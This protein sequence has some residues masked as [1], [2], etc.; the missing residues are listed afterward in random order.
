M[1]KSSLY[2]IGHGHKAIEEFIAELLAYD[3][4]FLIDVRSVPFSKW[5]PQFNQGN[6]ENYLKKYSIRYAYMGDSIGGRPLNDSC[7]DEDGYL[8]YERMAAFPQFKD[9][10]QRLINA[11]TLGYK[12]A[13]MCSETDPSQCHRSKLIGRELYF[14]HNVDMQHIV[15]KTRII[16]EPEII[17]MLTKGRWSPEPSLF[18]M[19]EEFQ[20]RPYFR[21][22]NS[23]KNGLEQE[24]YYD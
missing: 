17:A 23:Y 12:V 22:R 2:S 21:S 16:S 5:A 6:I 8:L 9:G 13:V 15:S 4:R 10:L 7:Y 14:G 24:L 19:F 11:N 18:D 3:I 1:M 20:E